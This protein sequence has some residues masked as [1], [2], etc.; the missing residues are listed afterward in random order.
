MNSRSPAI[1]RAGSI[2]MEP[3]GARGV[4]SGMIWLNAVLAAGVILPPNPV[5]LPAVR[6]AREAVQSAAMQYGAAA[7]VTAMMVRNL[8]L[9][10]EQAGYSNYAELYARHS[11]A[12]LEARF[13]PDDASLVPA[14][15]VLAE[16]LA[17]QE[18]YA[19][20]ERMARRAVAIGPAAEAHYGTALYNLGAILESEGQ[21]SE[22]AALYRRALAARETALPP[23]HPYIALTREALARCDSVT[24][25]R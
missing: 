2:S 15:N 9:A 22:A 21:R 4:L 5:A 8:A 24:K 17:S 13:G 18:R 19:E 23:G 7:P 25:H 10:F 6:A 11:L 1:L 20:A 16:A 12:S 14:L 3:A